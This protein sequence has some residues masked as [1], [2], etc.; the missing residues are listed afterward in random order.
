[1]T[2]RKKREDDYY[3]YFRGA[4]L[5]RRQANIA[6]LGIIFGMIGAVV[7]ILFAIMSKTVALSI[8]TLLALAGGAIGMIIW[9]R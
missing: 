6:G 3:V 7:V 5:T 2:D 8:V 9:R 1:M 4:K